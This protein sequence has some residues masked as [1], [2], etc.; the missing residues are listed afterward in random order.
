MPVIGAGKRSSAHPAGTPGC[1]VQYDGLL[2]TC[3]AMKPT[4]SRALLAAH[5]LRSSVRARPLIMHACEFV[6]LSR[7][8][9]GAMVS[10]IVTCAACFTQFELA[11]KYANC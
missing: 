8:A 2:L 4:S 7:S 9:V 3:T 11:E 5:E 1:P 6:H 10:L